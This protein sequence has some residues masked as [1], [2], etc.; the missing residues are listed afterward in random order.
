MY[1]KI[2]MVNQPLMQATAASTAFVTDSTPARSPPACLIASFTTS[3]LRPPIS[4]LRAQHRRPQQYRGG[5]GKG[6]G[7]GEIHI[8][9]LRKGPK[10][11]KG[12]PLRRLS[13]DSLATHLR[14]LSLQTFRA[15]PPSQANEESVAVQIDRYGR[16]IDA[17]GR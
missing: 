9:V 16:E 5:R 15:K 17:H 14:S 12:Q 10:G 3:A 7:V 4:T 8:C 13:S 11:P 6:G 2:H 1:Q